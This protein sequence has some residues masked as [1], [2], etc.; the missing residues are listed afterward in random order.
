[1]PQDDWNPLVPTPPD[2]DRQNQFVDRIQRRQ[3]LSRLLEAALAAVDP[4]PLTRHALAGRRGEHATLIA[5]GKASIGMCRGA[6]QALGATEGICVSNVS[7]PVPDGIEIIVG[8]H[9]VPGRGSFAAGRRV[10]EVAA[11]ATEPVIALVSGGG[12]ALCEHPIEGVSPRFISDVGQHLL[13]HGASIGEMNLVRRH[14]SA[15]KNG[16]ITRHARVP[17]ETYAISDV[18]GQDP[19]VIA[20]GPTVAAPL[21]PEAAIEAMTRHD[22]TVPD[23]VRLAIR[24][25]RSNVANSPLT[26]IGDGR[27]S[28]QAV[29]DAASAQGIEAHV[30]GGWLEGDA[31]QELNRL[32]D[33]AGEGITVAVGEPEVAVTGDGRGGRNTHVALLAAER[34]GGSSM[35]FAAFATDGVDGSSASAGA[36]VDGTTIERGGDPASAITSSDSATYLGAIGDLI[37]TGPTGTN[38]SDLWVVWR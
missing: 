16:G 20:S 30:A 37:R 22:I 28:A 9:P 25:R 23:E 21:D 15:V 10:L 14:L 38:V 27:V 31:R 7:G 18:C 2:H 32:L 12:S 19:S 6:A 8:D 33:L 29:V 5:I 26:V 13:E 4:E 34:L 1:M 11:A 3:T 36:I 35:L 24:A 17:V